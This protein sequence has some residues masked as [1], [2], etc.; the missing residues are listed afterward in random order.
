MSHFTE[1]SSN[2]TID[3]IDAIYPNTVN[4]QHEYIM[5]SLIDVDSVLEGA[6]FLFESI[7][8]SLWYLM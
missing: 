5:E 2:I 8:E 6:D 1:H 4:L 7:A 3:I